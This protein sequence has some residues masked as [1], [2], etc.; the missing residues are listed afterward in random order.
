MSTGALITGERIFLRHPRARDRE[1]FLERVDASTKLHGQ[2][3]AYPPTDPEAFAGFLR[4]SRRADV[5]SLLV[6]RKDDD[7]IVGVFNISQIVY[8]HLRSAYLGYYVFEPFAGQGYMHDGLQLVLRF[9]FGSLGLHR[10]EANIQPENESS[11]ALV[12]GAGF[13][14]EG[15]SPRY[16]KVAGRWRDHERWAILAEDRPRRAEGSGRTT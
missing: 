5:E 9:A 8:G 7:A 13:R 11:I 6:C 4:R 3:A 15:Y 2:W 16:L 14:L 12:K 10:L 1:R